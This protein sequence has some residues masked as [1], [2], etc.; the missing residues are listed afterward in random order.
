MD[1]EVEEEEGHEREKFTLIVFTRLSF[2]LS[3]SVS[4]AITQK[5]INTT[6]A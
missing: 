3:V 2:R 5:Y 6:S 4:L 1:E